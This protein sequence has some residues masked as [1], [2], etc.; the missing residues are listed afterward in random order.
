MRPPG[1]QVRLSTQWHRG[2]CPI[3]GGK[4]RLRNRTRLRLWRDQDSAAGPGLGEEAE[5][6][7]VVRAGESRWRSRDSESPR[8]C[9]HSRN[10][11]TRSQGIK[12]VGTNASMSGND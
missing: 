1:P 4:S 9:F 11:Y 7:A 6:R 12:D 3:A 2:W 5:V 10:S 8:E